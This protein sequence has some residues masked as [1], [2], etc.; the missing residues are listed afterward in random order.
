MPRSRSAERKQKN[1]S[2]NPF[3]NILLSAPVKTFK[4]QFSLVLGKGNSLLGVL[5]NIP[6]MR[7]EF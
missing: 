1:K 4:V 7:T 6:K 2:E 3:R 5:K